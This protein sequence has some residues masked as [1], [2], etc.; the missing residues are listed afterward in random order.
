[1]TA[2]AT[3]TVTIG[4][5][6]NQPPVAVDDTAAET[7]SAAWR[8]R[9]LANDSDPDGDPLTILSIGT[10]TLGSA[11]IS[12]SSVVY[13]PSATAV[14]GIDSFG[15][16]IG[17]GNGGTASATITVIISNLPNQPPVAVDDTVVVNPVGATIIDVLA[18]DS[19]P[20]GDPL[21][22]VSVTAPSSGSAT[23][24]GNMVTYTAAVPFPGTAT[25][26]YTISDGQGG[27]A[28]ATVTVNAS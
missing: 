2:S 21:S 5:L 12:G 4:N 3:I 14:G 16:S 9:V 28:T 23:I 19:D 18:N 13:T 20:D 7:G 22:I 27:T 6:P 24:I 25:F 17:D 8:D 26:D 1:G 11:T 10:P 15:Y